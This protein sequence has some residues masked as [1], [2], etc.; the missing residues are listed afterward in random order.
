MSICTEGIW[1]IA[2]DKIYLRL[3]LRCASS[4]G[5]P[6]IRGF[7]AGSSPAFWRTRLPMKAS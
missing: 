5:I 3:S 6:G 4:L 1:G 2:P 7:A